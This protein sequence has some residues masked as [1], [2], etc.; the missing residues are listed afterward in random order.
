MGMSKSD[1][2]LSVF[3]TYH[4]DEARGLNASSLRCVREVDRASLKE[5]LRLEINSIP[6]QKYFTGV[7]E[8]G[9]IRQKLDCL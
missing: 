8:D 7:T 6:S 1:K 3:S 2:F 5:R 4:H 9:A